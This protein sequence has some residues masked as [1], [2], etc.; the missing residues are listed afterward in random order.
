MHGEELRWGWVG[1]GQDS[2]IQYAFNAFG[3]TNKY[4]IEFGAMDGTILS[5]T[6]FLR[7]AQGWNG[8]LL[9]GNHQNFQ[10]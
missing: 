10:P 2:F 9:E 6:S 7:N 1:W 8:L 3:T 5:N 4:Y